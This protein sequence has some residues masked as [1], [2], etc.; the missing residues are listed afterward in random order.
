MA[1]KKGTK[2]P[3]GPPGENNL[4]GTNNILEASKKIAGSTDELKELIEE[5]E[6]KKK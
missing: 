2:F 1:D 4:P 6:E 5:A 3:N